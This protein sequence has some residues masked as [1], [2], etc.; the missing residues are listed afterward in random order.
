MKRLVACLVAAASLVAA[1]P[2]FAQ[3]WPSQPVKM[4]IPWPPGGGNDAL[5]RKLG[6]ALAPILGQPVVVENRAGANGM[7]GAEAVARAAP[8]GYTIMFHSVTTHAINPTFYSKI[9]YDTLGD[10]AP[11]TLIG[12]AAHVLVV[13]PAF[14]AKTL[15][16]LIE[17]AKEKPG[18]ISYASFG[19]WQLE[20]SCGRA[21]HQ[22]ARDQ[23]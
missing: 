2:A 18:A 9:A 4:V 15:K 13:N 7:I 21:F 23:A 16:E 17:M 8:D 11:V 6:E 19:S 10:F 22:H 14:A 1:V 3:T 20:P 5:G 12:E